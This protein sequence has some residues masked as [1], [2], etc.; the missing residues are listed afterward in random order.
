MELT[1]QMKEALRQT[2]VTMSAS[3]AEFAHQAGISPSVLCRWLAKDTPEPIR[4]RTWRKIL[5]IMEPHLTA[6]SRQAMGMSPNGISSWSPSIRV[7]LISAQVLLE[8]VPVI[9]PIGAFVVRR[10]RQEI[11]SEERPGRSPFAV[12]FDVLPV[13]PGE[14]SGGIIIVDGG[15][16]PESEQHVLARVSDDAGLILA[17]YIRK[18]DQ[19]QLIPLGGTNTVTLDC[20]REMGRLLWMFPVLHYSIPGPMADR[21]EPIAE[22]ELSGDGATHTSR[23]E[24][25]KITRMATYTTQLLWILSNDPAW[26]VVR[27]APGYVLNVLTCVSIRTTMAAILKATTEVNKI[28]SRITTG[29]NFAMCKISILAIVALAFVVY[30]LSRWTMKTVPFN[31]ADGAY[32]LMHFY[33]A[34]IFWLYWTRPSEA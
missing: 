16:C 15:S 10:S 17:R 13:L 1:A 2:M 12:K 34:V 22:V 8:Y 31:L 25:G 29:H 32:L 20:R 4:P 11:H 27:S 3:Q 23:P 30:S 28:R 5:A 24:S 19:V 18:N 21:P 26:R 33:A 14:S 6:K 9:E 7:P